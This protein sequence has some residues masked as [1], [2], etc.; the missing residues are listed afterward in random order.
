MKGKKENGRE[1]IV[2]NERG[3]KGTGKERK[4]GEEIKVGF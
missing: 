3:E 1:R 2:E 4:K